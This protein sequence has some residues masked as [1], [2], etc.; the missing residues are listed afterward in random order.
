MKPALY[1]FHCRVCGQD[2]PPTDNIDLMKGALTQHFLDFHV[3]ETKCI[4]KTE[5]EVAET[6]CEFKY[7]ISV[8]CQHCDEIM[9]GTS[10]NTLDYI[11]THSCDFMDDRKAD[12][13]AQA[14]AYDRKDNTAPRDIA[15]E[16]DDVIYG[17][18][19]RL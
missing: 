5:G 15:F 4:K 18:D 14:E 12:L 9:A 7:H 2:L 19:L 16:S 3:T 13:N 10:A 8:Q 17:G 11:L 6:I 1:H